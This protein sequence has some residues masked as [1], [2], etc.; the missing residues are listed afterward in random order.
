MAT[1]VLGAVGAAVGALIGSS[2]GQGFDRSV[3]FGPGEMTR[4]GPR[5][6]D[7]DVQSSALG[8]PIPRIFGTVRVAGNVLWSSGL[9]EERMETQQ[10]GGKGGPRRPR[11]WS[12]PIMPRWR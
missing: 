2:I 9:M 6:S 4:E 8:T 3:L 12:F 10:G 1:L 11:R 7:T 5:L